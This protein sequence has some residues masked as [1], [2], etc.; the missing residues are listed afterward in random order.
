[1]I[2]IAAIG[3][4]K[5][6]TSEYVLEKDYL[7]R[8]PWK[9][10][11]KES[12]IRSFRS[13]EHRKQLEGEQ[14]LASAQKAVI[15]IVLDERGKELTS[16]VFATQCQRWIEE[17]PVAFLIGGADGHDELVRQRARM[18]LSFGKMTW[19]HKLTRVL[20]AEQLYRAY[21]IIHH[22]PYHRE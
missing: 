14:L 13:P 3:K 21:T 8:I 1:M 22:H 15:N 6:G 18:V 17:G 20:L 12:E 19:P 16:Q 11:V 9:V 10:D 2:T 4:L 5:S 7:K